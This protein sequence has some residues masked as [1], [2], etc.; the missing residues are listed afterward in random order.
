[1]GAGSNPCYVFAEV[2]NGLGTDAYFILGDNWAPVPGATTAY[3]GDLAGSL[4][5]GLNE[6]EVA[7]LKSKAYTS[8]LFM[9]AKGATSPNP[10]LLD[11]SK[12]AVDK[13]TNCLFTD[14]YTN[15][16][17]TMGQSATAG[18]TKDIMV[19]SY[20]AVATGSTNDSGTTYEDLS[21]KID[22]IMNGAKAWA[23]SN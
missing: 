1:M 14:V 17:F 3:T 19:K 15:K 22:E 12:S 23:A 5:Y 11:A 9:Y 7:T 13:Y 18:T 16:N 4:T 20:L 8:G 21:K 2:E 6:G 10:G